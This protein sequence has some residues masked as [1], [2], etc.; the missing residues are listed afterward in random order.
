[1]FSDFIIVTDDD[2]KVFRNSILHLT[3]GNFFYII[4]SS[5]DSIYKFCFSDSRLFKVFEILP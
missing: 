2:F 3:S 5:S 1:M 4:Q